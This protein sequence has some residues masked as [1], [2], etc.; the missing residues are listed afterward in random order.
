MSGRAEKDREKAREKER[1][2]AL[3]REIRPSAELIRIALGPDDVLAP[4]VD[5]KAPGRGVWIT[6]SASAITEAVRKN[7]FARSL[8]QKVIVPEDLAQL[9]ATRLEQRLLGA[10]GLARKA[11][12]LMLGGAKTRS[13]I[14]KGEIIAL[15]TATDA[16]PDGRQK[17]L[18]YFKARHEFDCP[19][20][21]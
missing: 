15:F 16:A 9:T 20:A 14:E 19:P 8:K 10:L 17:M 12:Q 11:G 4:D 7:I 5:G 6:L 13:A 21:L 18:G 3:T 1:Q 2:C